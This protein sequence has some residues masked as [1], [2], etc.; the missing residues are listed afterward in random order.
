MGCSKSKA[1]QSQAS[2]AGPVLLAK[3][4][5]KQ[6]AQ[7]EEFPKAKPGVFSTPLP[8]D[9]GEPTK[10]LGK[11][12]PV[13]KIWVFTHAGRKMTRIAIDQGFDWVKNVSPLLPG[14]PVWS[15]ATHFGFLESGEMGV[16]FKD[17]TDKVIKAGEAYF[18]PPGHLPLMSKS[19]VMVDFSQDETYTNKQFIAGEKAEEK[20]DEPKPA[21]ETTEELDMFCQP[22]S[23]ELLVVEPTKKL[24]G[25]KMW[26]KKEAGR[27]MMRIDIA[28]GFDWR[29]SVAPMLPKDAK[30][31]SPEWCP[32]THFG[33]LE[34]GEMG[35]KLKD[36]T[37]TTIMAGQSYYVPPGH[38]PMMSQA[39]RMVEFSQDETYTNKTFVEKK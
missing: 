2:G 9:L 31:C 27:Q 20:P 3:E 6:Q 36:G 21:V 7:K 11:D 17:G 14:C 15:P 18:I 4:D 22:C 19:A 35:I 24:D 23:D 12:G 5:L 32:A 16:K 1:I 38:V 29:K 37:E 8:A 34:K 30:G 25:A 33:Y 26:I 13:A 39:A 10:V 28:E